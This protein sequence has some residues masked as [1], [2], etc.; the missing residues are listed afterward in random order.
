[1]ATSSISRSAH[2]PMQASSWP[3]NVAGP[4]ALIVKGALATAATVIPYRANRATENR[5]PPKRNPN[6]TKNGEPNSIL[7]SSLKLDERCK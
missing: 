7:K 6:A 4:P 2:T 5:I 1:L 3:S